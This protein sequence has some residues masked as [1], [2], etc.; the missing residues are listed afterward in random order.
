MNH[1]DGYRISSPFG[2][3]TNPFGTSAREYHKGIDLVKPHDS[4]IQAFVA[5]KVLH[6]Q[7]GATGSGFG[8][9]G[10]VVAILDEKE[11]LHVYAHLNSCLVKVNQQVE[12]GQVIGRQGSTGR[13]TGSH[14]H[15]EIRRTFTPSF[16]WSANSDSVYNPT[17]YLDEYYKTKG[18][19]P[20]MEHG[21]LMHNRYNTQME[22]I[23]KLINGRQNYTVK[24]TDVRQLKLLKGKYRLEFVYVKGK[25]VS[26]I[27][28]IKGAA[29]G[30][31]A[32]LRD[33]ATSSLIGLSRSGETIHSYAYG[34]VRQW[35]SFAY[36]KGEIQ[37]G[38]VNHNLPLEMH[39]QGIPQLMANKKFV[40]LDQHN[41]F[42]LN[43]NWLDPAQATFAGVD[44]EG[45]LLLGIADG[46]TRSD[47]GLTYKNMYDLMDK[48]GAVDAIRFDGGGSTVLAD[49]SGVISQNKIERILD[50]AVL[51]YL[52]DK[53][54]EVAPAVG[55]KDTDVITYGDLKKL[56]LIK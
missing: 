26:E 3:R 23:P 39:V 49:Q 19:E 44:A 11:A 56:G 13:S 22:L 31:N 4:A 28:K 33:P 43:T 47:I 12:R 9:F 7:M 2:W 8:N 53:P 35:P 5:G 51:V 16:G 52:V 18:V 30:F 50:H 42:K 27:V 15:Y 38:I 6:A 41:F 10:N 32:C 54:A 24:G 1:F 14:L 17:D 20:A 25:K 48:W 29:F 37:I 34:D 55:Y 36:D 40:A 45:N 21:N 46:R